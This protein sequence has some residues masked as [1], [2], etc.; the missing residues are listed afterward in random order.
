MAVKRIGILAVILAFLLA[1]YA[2]L[3][4]SYNTETV[5][6]D[7]IGQL[8]PEEL[9]EIIQ[10]SSIK[11][12][13]INFVMPY[14]GHRLIMTTGYDT[15]MENIQLSKGS[16]Q[17]AIGAK[18]TILGDKAADKYFRNVNVIGNTMT[19]YE[20]SY[21]VQGIVKNS[22]DIYIPYDEELKALNWQ[23]KMVKCN[24]KKDK[25]FYLAIDTFR[26]KLNAL[27]L[28][29]YDSIIYKEIMYIYINLAIGIAL[30]ILLLLGMHLI[31]LDAREI[32]KLASG[33]LEEKRTSEWYAYIARNSRSIVKI[34]AVIL[35]ILL[36]MY[37]IIR[38]VKLME[39]P[40]SMV[41]DNLFSLSSYIKTI[42][43]NF[44]KYLLHL[45]NGSSDI[46]ISSKMINAIL[47]LLIFFVLTIEVVKSVKVQKVV[48]LDLR[49]KKGN[50]L[51]LQ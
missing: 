11:A 17:L 35:A 6:F 14:Q 22:D 24:F 13:V 48:H 27:G 46:L 4:Y 7:F 20:R 31:K 42:R 25:Y 33:Y 37:C 21:E 16:W 39:L 34:F 47:V 30:C 9:Q 40:P 50:K 5:E 49:Q 8:S 44:E 2:Y 32:K 28:D 15:L 36:I 26:T 29:V 18:Q 43:L 23:K 12:Y 38:L 19:I 1:S 45:R 51:P 41:P 10:G 3:L